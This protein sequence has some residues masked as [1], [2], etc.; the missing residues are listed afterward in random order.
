MAAQ[1]VPSATVPGRYTGW[2]VGAAIIVGV[3]AVGAA[4]WFMHH[5]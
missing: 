3:L 5:P 2:L 4:L 1:S